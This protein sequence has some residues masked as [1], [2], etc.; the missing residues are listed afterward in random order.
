MIHRRL[1]MLLLTALICGCG[2]GYD[3]PSLINKLRVLAVRADPPV[4][5]A[6][7]PTTLQPLI[8]GVAS[9]EQLCYA[10]AFCPFAW[11]KDGN[12]RCFDP[13]LQRSLGTS[14]TA[15]MTPATLFS[16]LAEAPAVFEDLGIKIPDGLEPG[17][18]PTEGTE[19]AQLETYILFKFATAASEGGVCPTDVAGWIDAPCK[20]R[21]ACIAGYK[22]LAFAQKPEQAHANPTLETVELDGVAWPEDVTPTVGW[23]VGNPDDTFFGLSNGAVKLTPRWSEES[24]ETI[25][26]SIDPASTTLARESLLFSWFSDAGDYEK[27]RSYDDVPENHLLPP[28]VDDLPLRIWVVVRDGRNGVDWVQRHLRV[29][30]TALVG[31]PL[32]NAVP[33]LPGCP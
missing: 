20:D 19:N 18:T 4:V 30:K 17:A 16:A 24:R 9:G 26:K 27:Q 1:L 7:G 33:S 31:H 28:C 12:F 10:W 15:T 6:T 22:R 3:P 11:P 13:R 32:C 21:S 29:A 23:Y 14:A 25:G 8:A 2:G 5:R